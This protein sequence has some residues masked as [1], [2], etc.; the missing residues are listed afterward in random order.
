MLGSMGVGMSLEPGPAAYL[1]ELRTRQ[2]NVYRHEGRAGHQKLSY[3]RLTH[4][5]RKSQLNKP[6]LF[7]Y[8][9]VNA[10]RNA[11]ALSNS[12]GQT[13]EFRCLGRTAV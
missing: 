6:M 1:C 12:R 10:A 5:R 11:Y 2:E 13:P 7:R 8:L 3:S 9:P 4:R